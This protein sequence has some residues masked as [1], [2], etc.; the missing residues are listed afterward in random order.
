MRLITLR[1]IFRNFR[2]ELL[3]SLI[4]L[5][6]LAIGI[7]CFILI[8]LYATDELSFDKHHSKADRIYRLNEFYEAND[9]AGERSS[10][11]PF[12]VVE[13]LEGDYPDLIEHSVRFFNFQAP[14]LTVR[15]EP[16]DIEFNERRFL[17]VDSTYAN[18]FDLPLVK[19]TVGTALSKPNSVVISEA[20][21]AKYFPNEDPMGKMLR[22]QDR[23]DFMVTGVMPNMPLTSHFHAD[24][25][26][27]LSSIRVMY[28]GTYPDN[29]FW[30]PCWTYVVL[31][32]GVDPAEL[33][34]RFP[35]FVKNHFPED[36]RNDITLK[37]QAL[38]DI[39][40]RSKLEF[41]IEPNGDESDVYTFIGIAFFVLGIA[42]LNF[43]NLMTATSVRRS[44][45]VGLKKTLGSSRRGLFLRFLS[46]SVLMS[47]AGVILAVVLSFM[48]LPLFN[49]FTGKELNLEILRPDIL[50]GLLSIAVIVGIL[51]GI[52]PAIII[53]SFRPI[54]ALKLKEASSGKV[55]RK[56]LVTIQFAVSF[57]LIIFTL[58]ANRQL[59]FLQR[60]DMG[61]QKDNIIMVPVMRT[62][63]GQHYKL[64]TDRAKEDHTIES[65]TTLEE[66]L[67]S[68][69]Q[70]ANYR[71]EGME[72]ASLYPRLNVRHDFLTTFN[73]PL[74]AGRDYSIDQP[75]DDS[76][77]LVVNESLVRGLNWTPENAIG[78]S[79]QFGRFNGQIVGVF[80]DFNFT[81]KHSP[82]G[83]LV[84]HLNTRPLA[85]NLFLKYMAVRITGD[86]VSGSIERLKDLWDETIPSKPFEYFFLD[87][88]LGN[89]YRA[90]ANLSRVVVSFSSLAI[91]VACLGLFGLASYDAEMRRREISIR[92]VF[93][94]SVANI[95]TMVLS[96]YV[97]LLVVAIIVACP[98]VYLA[99]SKWLSG[100][101]YHIDMPF[102]S[103][104]LGA[105]VIVSMGILAV[106]YKCWQ[107]AVI[108]PV[109]AL[110]D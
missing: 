21:A 84:L 40:L 52:Y 65:I 55:F 61:F 72:R 70:T 1:L 28:N 53:S 31:K 18:V 80:K 44:K 16:S 39:H 10:S 74:L 109:K 43:V 38:T 9:G 92:K 78:R 110:K 37:V 100:F 93:G 57:A 66:V 50:L 4:N 46:E 98:L 24:F 8:V 95:V 86:D 33:E 88:E 104:V 59:K 23:I 49:D 87:N 75:T 2:K 25:L 69:F 103:F 26:G 56:T 14:A 60:S 89:L 6:G 71:F 19:G 11:L 96:Q 32:E 48:A 91:L 81:S 58:A 3:Y 82:I 76:L 106:G 20:A 97:R 108:N 85:F 102:D 62:P 36:I 94:G 47:I 64:F 83:P 7:T 15:Y 101:A 105:L 27:S 67:G 63:I 45:E 51:S 30:N 12:P 22:F 79:F 41:E 99:L 107:A 73:I 68:K 34:A 17:L 54:S 13:V 42:C 90:E 35:A 29:W 77:A 5:W